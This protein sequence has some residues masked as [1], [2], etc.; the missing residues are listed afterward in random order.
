MAA[1]G[2]RASTRRS[3]TTRRPVTGP[4]LADHADRPAEA[5]GGG[6]RAA[7]CTC[8][9][10]GAPTATPI[11]TV[12]VYD[13]AADTWSTLRRDQP[14]AGGGRGRRGGRRQGAAGRW[15]HRRR[16]RHSGDRWV[17]DP[18]SGLQRGRGVP[19]PGL[20]DVVRRHRRQG[21]LRRWSRRRRPSP[22]GTRTTRTPTRGRR[23]PPCRRTGGRRPDGAAGG[24]LVIAGG[25]TNGRQHAHQRDDRVRPGRQHAG[26]TCRT[27][28]SRATA[29]RARAAS[30]RSV[31][32]S[33]AQLASASRGTSAT[34]RTASTAAEVPWL[35]ED[36]QTFTLAPG[37]S[38]TVKVTLAA[39]T[40]AGVTQPGDYTA[41]IGV[42]V[43]QPVPGRRRWTSPCTSCRRR[44]GARSAA[45]SPA[46]AAPARCRC[47]PSWR[48]GCVEPG[49][50]RTRCRPE[51][52][53]TYAIWLPK[54]RY[55]VIVSRDGWRSQFKRHQVT[56]RLRRGARL[57]AAAV[58]GLPDQGR[59][60]LTPEDNDGSAR[61]PT[62][63]GRCLCRDAGQATGSSSPAG[64]LEPVHEPRNPKVVVP[65][66]PATRSSPRAVPSPSYR[67][68]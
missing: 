37:A 5:A 50:R 43:E 11:A 66:A 27:P 14:G 40:A 30:T 48:S 44:T 28:T 53:G 47:R 61:D 32:S 26:R 68:G 31:A 34:W 46:R 4:R 8:S 62:D 55:D 60:R 16:L 21:L 38:R 35:S 19:A 65:P 42:R 18:A 57:L 17:F 67:T 59:W 64:P 25:V 54:G 20:V 36:P 12:D 56:G 23:S 7:S 63:P 6:R 58:R 41:E 39:T 45:R 9:V 15:L 49:H 22:T 3:C 33:R 1:T 51:A 29:A 24:L 2:D 13:P 52:D 10:A